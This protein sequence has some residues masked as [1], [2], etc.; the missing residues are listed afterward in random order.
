[1]DG[2]LGLGGEE[3][4]VA[5]RLGVTLCHCCCDAC[6]AGLSG[7][8]DGDGGSGGWRGA[9]AAGAMGC[10]ALGGL[11]L[12]GKWSWSGVGVVKACC[13]GLLYLKLCG[14][15]CAQTLNLLP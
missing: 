13:V 7:G 10:D 2:F 6:G 14:A 8:G 1:M 3:G 15:H 4:A 12:Q 11:L 5:L 9:L